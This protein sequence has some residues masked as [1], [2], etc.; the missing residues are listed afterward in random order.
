MSLTVAHLLEVIR[1]IEVSHCCLSANSLPLSPT[2]IPLSLRYSFSLLL[3]PLSYSAC[4]AAICCFPYPHSVAL[5]PNS[6][7]GAARVLHRA[8]LADVSNPLG[9]RC[10]E[11]HP[12]GQTNCQAPRLPH[13]SLCG[14]GSSTFMSYFWPQFFPLFSNVCTKLLVLFVPLFLA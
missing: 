12:R 1:S 11:K 8:A 4:R 10:L 3:F 5:R 7:C 13:C 14:S 2:T 6:A 9:F